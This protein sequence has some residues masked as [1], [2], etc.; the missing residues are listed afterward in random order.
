ME[1]VPGEFT[2][3]DQ[4]LV[5]MVAAYF[6]FFRLYWRFSGIL[7]SPPWVNCVVTALL[8]GLHPEQLAEMIP[9]EMH[10][11]TRLEAAEMNRQW[12]ERFL[13]VL[14]S[15][16]HV[17]QAT[18]QLPTSRT[19]DW[20]SFWWRS[21]A[22]EVERLDVSPS[23]RGRGLDRAMGC[24]FSLDPADLAMSGYLPGNL[25]PKGPTRPF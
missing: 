3:Q 1:V 15:A 18:V 10:E 2:F 20:R 23:F 6:G 11:A 4:A 17:F 16:R 7:T 9:V 5:S 8:F 13:P 21:T 25:A 19:S 22:R 14:D 12:Q 24:T